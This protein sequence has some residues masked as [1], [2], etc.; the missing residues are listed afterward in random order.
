VRVRGPRSIPQQR[1]LQFPSPRHCR[2][3][4]FAMFLCD[5]ATASRASPEMTKT[6]KDHFGTCPPP[7]LLERRLDL[8]FHILGFLVVGVSLCFSSRASPGLT[9]TRKDP[10]RDSCPHSSVTR[11][12]IESASLAKV[13]FKRYC[14]LGQMADVHYGDNCFISS[15]SFFLVSTDYILTRCS[16]LPPDCSHSL[17]PTLL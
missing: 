1:D 6:S 17:L 7:V 13:A 5:Q 12:Q 2:R 8:Q 16:F 9:K 15:K 14:S 4:R 11:M 10:F 3:W